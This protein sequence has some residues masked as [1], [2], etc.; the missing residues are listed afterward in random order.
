M[1][2]LTGPPCSCVHL[3]HPRR[4]RRPPP[5][6]PPGR[7]LP[8]LLRSSFHC[9][10]TAAAGRSVGRSA[11]L[12]LLRRGHDS[13]FRAC[14][15][16]IHELQCQVLGHSLKYRVQG[17]INPAIHLIPSCVSSRPPL[18]GLVSSIL[19]FRSHSLQVS[20]LVRLRRRRVATSI[21]PRRTGIIRE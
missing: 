4:R 1:Q 10:C 20:L 12:F 3:L 18:F 5:P 16:F 19:L 15:C 9:L 13:R 8:L 21:I 6:P 2:G 11:P 14:T 17:V 7:P